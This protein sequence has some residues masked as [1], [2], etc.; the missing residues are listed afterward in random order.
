[1]LFKFLIVNSKSIFT[2]NENDTMDDFVKKIYRY[3]ESDKVLKNEYS[4]QVNML[5][6]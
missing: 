3:C 5:Q 4:F 1:M 2:N 6:I